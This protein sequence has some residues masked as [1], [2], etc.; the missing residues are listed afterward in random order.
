MF[1]RQ[2]IQTLLAKQVIKEVNHVPGEYVSNVF[3]CEKPTPGNFG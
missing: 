3:L 2:E 1:L